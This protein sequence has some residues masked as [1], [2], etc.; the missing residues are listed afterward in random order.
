MLT[1]LDEGVSLCDRVNRREWLRVGS[2]GAGG[3]SL[4]HLLAAK[5]SA[6]A[7]S[8]AGRAASFGKAKSVILFW[9]TGGAPQHE[10]W[11]P[12][13]DAPAEIRGSFGPIASKTPGLF[14]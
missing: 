4:A 3:L 6:R 5:N 13:P 8:G 9:L 7:V 2:L 1:I 11:D 12:K 10:T 14:V